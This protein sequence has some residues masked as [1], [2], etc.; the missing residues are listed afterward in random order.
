MNLVAIVVCSPQ[1]SSTFDDQ[2]TQCNLQS[3]GAYLT[4]TDEIHYI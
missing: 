1:Q 4:E 3:E 2:N